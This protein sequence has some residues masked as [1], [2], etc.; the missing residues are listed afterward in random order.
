LAALSSEKK[1][2]EGTV[3][4][5]AFQKAGKGQSGA[6][7][8]SE[9]GKNLLM[10]VLLFPHELPVKKI[11]MLNKVVALAV[12]DLISEFVPE[13]KIKWPND[14]YVADK[15][16]CGMLIEN[17]LRG[18][19]IQYSIAGIGLNI[20]QGVFP[21]EILNPTSLKI[22][23]G[24]IFSVDEIFSPLCSHLES[25]YLQLKA[26]QEEKLNRDYISSLYRFGEKCFYEDAHGKFSAQIENVD[27]DGRLCLLKE[28][29][30]KTKYAMKE[31]RFLV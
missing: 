25:R 16:I 17:S 9:P 14:I 21:T 12:R 26:G 2:P 8:N 29:G 10:S 31:V 20:N 11:F 15:K 4:I 5:T 23:T 19:Q 22:I 3:V 1:L 18:N 24:K 7:W 6:Q 28:D 30:C 13:V 27:E